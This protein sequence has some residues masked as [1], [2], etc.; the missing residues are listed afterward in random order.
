MFRIILI[1]I[2]IFFIVQGNS[3]AQEKPVRDSSWTPQDTLWT[4]RD[5][6]VTI[7]DSLKY[8]ALE[9]YSKKSKITSFLYKLIFRPV[10]RPVLQLPEQNIKPVLAY[11]DIEGMAIRN[12]RI[13]VLDPFGYSI[14]DTSRRP[15]SLFQRT[16]N[17]LHM[18]TKT[19][20]IRNLLLF[21]QND[22]YDSLLVNESERLI[23]SQKFVHDV[24]IYALPVSRKSDSVDVYIR[25]R[26]I[27]SIVA[28]VEFTGSKFEIDITEHNFAGVGHMLH[29]NFMKYRR[30]DE[31]ITRLSYSIPNIR[32]SFIT[33]NVQYLFSSKMS[34][35]DSLKNA[36]SF[37]S[38]VSANPHY[39]FE[40]NENL[41]RS[42]E[43][44]RSFYSPGVKWAGGIFIGQ[45][46]TSLSYF[47]NDTLKYIPVRTNI[48][49]IW[50]ARSWQIFGRSA[51]GRITNL[52]LSLRILRANY[53]RIETII[54][55]ADYFNKEKIY[56]AGIG[57]TSRKYIRDRYIF[58]YGKIEDVPA[59]KS[60][61]ITIGLD[62][63]HKENKWYFGIQ[64]AW[65]DYHPSGYLSTHLEFGTLKGAAGF[66][67]GVISG[68]INYFTPLFNAGKWKLR[69]FVRPSFVFGLKRLPTDN[70][71]L[72]PHINGFERLR[73]PANHLLVLSL[74]TQ[75]YAPWNIIGFRIGPYFFSSMGLLGNTDTGFRKSKIYSLLGLGILVKNDYLMF[76]T[77]QFSITFYPF[78]PER[79]YNVIRSNIYQ[80]TDYGFQNFEISKP[81]VVE[82]R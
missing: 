75:S 36:T 46:V 41:L 39:T 61:G 14:H 35:L 55:P 51:D 28:A 24:R 50:G 57:I 26:D 62:E 73:D 18:K 11:P 15:V 38:P 79:G 77:F 25:V 40:D 82:Y 67:Q 53:P 5:S 9:N 76:R 22:R 47:I 27:W 80:T 63:A 2:L 74:Q 33:A 17:N 30:L 71:T 52:I 29:G 12:I 23:R 65:G 4:I 45:M 66:Q 49:D 70:L 37:Y 21:Q 59:G 43:L 16:G 1:A 58:N 68:R 64:A 13:D 60:I 20:I 81:Q 8:K 3:I 32:N 6:L 19:L 34:L 48:Q 44:T 31:N 72:G 78:L 56:F 42:I 10:S 7:K 54:N 69:Q